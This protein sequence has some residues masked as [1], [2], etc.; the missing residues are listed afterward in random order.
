MFNVPTTKKEK[1]EME[2]VQRLSRRT[3][4]L[5]AEEAERLLREQSLLVR[6][7]VLELT[8]PET[9]PRVV[10][11][12]VVD[13]LEWPLIFQSVSKLSD[14]VWREVMKRLSR[15]RRAM[16]PAAAFLMEATRGASDEALPDACRAAVDALGTAIDGT[17]QGRRRREPEA[18]FGEALHVCARAANAG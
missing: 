13:C 14:E 10:A 7:K 6:V 16:G 11:S 1:R 2:I 4:P 15:N 18:R 8:P 5:R 17:V 3:E 9:N 12:A